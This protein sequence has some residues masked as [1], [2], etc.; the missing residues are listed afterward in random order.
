MTR[1]CCCLATLSAGCTT[2]LIDGPSGSAPLVPIMPW[3]TSGA[4]S[5]CDNPAYFGVT[6]SIDAQKNDNAAC[7][8]AGNKAWIQLDLGAVRTITS[9]VTTGRLASNQW[10][11]MYTVSVSKDGSTFVAVPCKNQDKDGRCVGNTDT[12]TRKVNPLKA[13]VQARYVRVSVKDYHYYASLQMGVE[14][15]TGPGMQLLSPP[16]H[17]TPS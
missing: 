6:H 13:S 12:T 17:A 2:Q 3:R 7:L 10:V 16:R 14:V 15:C 8:N 1:A 5:D 9:V 11:T 4:H